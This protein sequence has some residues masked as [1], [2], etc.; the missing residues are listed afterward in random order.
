MFFKKKPPWRL[1][2]D[3]WVSQLRQNTVDEI[4]VA[5]AEGRPAHYHGACNGCIFKPGNTSPDGI[6]HC[7]GCR[8]MQ[9]DQRLPELC[10]RPRSSY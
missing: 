4:A 1:R 9:W 5:Q 2:L 8:N 10:E 3:H 7:L 6:R